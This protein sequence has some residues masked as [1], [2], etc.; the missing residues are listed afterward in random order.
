MLALPPFRETW[1]ASSEDITPR[2]S[3]VRT[4]APIP[5]GSPVLR[6]VASCRES[7]QVAT[8]PCC[9]Q[10][11]PDVI[12]VNLSSNAWS[13]APAVPQN[14]CACSLF[15]VIG[16]PQLESGSASRCYPRIRLLAGRVSRVQTFLNVQ[17]FEFARL[18]DRSYRCTSS[19]RAAETFT[20][21]HTRASFPPH[22]PD[23]LAVRIQAIDG[24]RTS[25]ALDS[26]SCR[27][28]PPVARH[29]L[30]TVLPLTRRSDRPL[31]S[32]HGPPCCLRPGS[33]GSASGVNFVEATT[34]FT[35]VAAR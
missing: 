27:L 19:R 24:T 16:L 8:S 29:V 26:Q 7:L 20:S 18:P 2:S 14:A 33:E 35:C 12:P 25:T 11:L 9:H 23:M 1:T 28:L 4:H 6:F 13:H 21:G 10:N 34:G 3:L 30:V 5:R 15:R 22:A 31:R 17:A 32:A